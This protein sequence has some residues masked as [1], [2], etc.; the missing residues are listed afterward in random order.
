MS[1]TFSSVIGCSA[2]GTSSSFTGEGVDSTTGCTS[3]TG[4]SVGTSDPYR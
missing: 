1:S 2:R 4:T 3:T